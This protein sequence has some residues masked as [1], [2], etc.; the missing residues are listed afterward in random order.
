[1]CCLLLCNSSLILTQTGKEFSVLNGNPSTA[2]NWTPDVTLLSPDTLT[3]SYS[4][5]TFPLLYQFCRILV[6][7]IVWLRNLVIK[8][9]RATCSIGAIVSRLWDCSQVFSERK[10]F[11][12][13]V[14]INGFSGLSLVIHDAGWKS[15]SRS[16]V[17]HG[18]MFYF[19]PVCKSLWNEWFLSCIFTVKQRTLKSLQYI[20]KAGMLKAVQLQGEASHEVSMQCTHKLNEVPH[21][22]RGVLQENTHS[23]GLLSCSWTC[24]L[25]SLRLISPLDWSMFHTKFKITVWKTYWGCSKSTGVIDVFTKLMNLEGT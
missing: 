18:L 25:I 8:S 12:D 9:E 19:S 22:F 5:I 2:W 11:T 13:V 14:L 7:C 6:P 3:S 4:F 24:T 16:T 21:D 15:L 20:K 1:M 23:P 17:E 10:K